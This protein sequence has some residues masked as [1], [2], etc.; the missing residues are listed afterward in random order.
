M[1]GVRY[2]GVAD[3]EGEGVVVGRRRFDIKVRRNVAIG[4][5]ISRTQQ[6]SA[7][8]GTQLNSTGASAFMKKIII[9]Q[10]MY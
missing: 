4:Y 8:R 7:A 5:L 3:G 10:A 1:G 2:G 6:M 9:S